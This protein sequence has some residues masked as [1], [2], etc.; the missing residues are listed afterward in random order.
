MC[1]G[2]VLACARATRLLTPLVATLVCVLQVALLDHLDNRA[3]EDSHRARLLVLKRVFS[4]PMVGFAPTDKH[5]S[6]EEFYAA[7]GI[8][9][10]PQPPAVLKAESD[11]TGKQPVVR[12]DDALNQETL[13]AFFSKYALPNGLLDYESLYHRVSKNAV[14]RGEGKSL[15]ATQ[16]AYQDSLQRSA[17]RPNGRPFVGGGKVR[18]EHLRSVLFR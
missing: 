10:L 11:R 4:S 6:F 9:G 15:A 17:Y 18:S 2:R 14:R 5:V 1:R 16:Q 8:L 7:M 13:A 12:G 3:K